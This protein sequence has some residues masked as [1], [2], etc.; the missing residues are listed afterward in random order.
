MRALESALPAM[1]DGRRAKF[2]FLPQGED[3]D[4]L[5]RDIGANNFILLVNKAMPLEEYLFSSQAEGL[6]LGSLDGRAR[7]STMA[8][9]LIEKLPQGV[10]KEL[11]MDS[12]AERTGLSRDKLGEILRQHQRNKQNG[13]PAALSPIPTETDA[14]THFGDQHPVYAVQDRPKPKQRDSQYQPAETTRN[15]VLYA[16]ALLLHEPKA[17]SQIETPNQLNT[18]EDPNM[19]LLLAMLELLNK[20]PDSTPAMLIGHWYGEP[21]GETLQLLLQAERLIP[22]TNIEQELTDT[23][24]HL[25][26]KSQKKQNLKQQ[27]DNILSKDY[28][29]LSDD[30]KQQ[31]KQL[32]RQKHDLSKA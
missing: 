5:V 10:F 24:L 22:E 23:L 16:I 18:D 21:W 4:S 12:L 2:L 14:E 13:A 27:V 17:A 11:M 29:Q 1:E 7:M 32:L 31:L 25:S 20:R 28:A 9:P 6:E 8:A 3:P 19:P 30:E 26:R 15:P